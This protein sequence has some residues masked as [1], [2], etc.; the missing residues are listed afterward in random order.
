VRGR[1]DDGRRARLGGKPLR[2]L[3]LADPLAERLDDPPAAQIRAERDREARERITQNGGPES[4]AR[5]PAV[6]SVS[7]MTPI[8]FWA[9]FVPWASA[10][11]D[12]ETIWPILKPRVTVPSSARAV[13]R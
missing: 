9:S 3:D 13:I 7:V 5:T 6:I 11:I 8:V 4:G 2:G 12:A 10:T 1:E